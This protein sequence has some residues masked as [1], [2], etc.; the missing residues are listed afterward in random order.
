M[1][2]VHLRPRQVVTSHVPNI[3]ANNGEHCYIHMLLYT[4]VL[5]L[6]APDLSIRIG[7]NIPYPAQ[8]NALKNHIGKSSSDTLRSLDP[9]SLLNCVFIDM[10]SLTKVLSFSFGRS[11]SARD[12]ISITSSDIRQK[13]FLLIR[14][15]YLSTSLASSQRFFDAKNFG[16]SYT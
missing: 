3:Y 16:V 14:A 1:A 12:Y 13:S 5:P 9:N 10:L 4:S 2:W 11:Y 8:A 6:T 7:T 15:I